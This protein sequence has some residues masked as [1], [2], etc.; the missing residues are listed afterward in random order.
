M[1]AKSLQTT[2][3]GCYIAKNY[4]ISSAYLFLKLRKGNMYI[5][6]LSIFFNF[7]LV[8]HW[9][10]TYTVYANII[11]TNCCATGDSPFLVWSG[12]RAIYNWMVSY[13][14]DTCFNT[15]WLPFT[16]YFR[17]QNKWI[18]KIYKGS[19][20]KTMHIKTQ[21]SAINKVSKINEVE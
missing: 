11:Y 5:S 3:F 15:F 13:G 16:Y 14:N 20:G 6:I 1:N 8:T 17:W 9:V 12:V 2:S 10:K 7:Y 21:Q 18:L 4:S 19:K